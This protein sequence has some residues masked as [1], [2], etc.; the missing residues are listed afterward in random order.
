MNAV[1]EVVEEENMGYILHKLDVDVV[2]MVDVVVN[3]H[4]LRE[5]STITVKILWL[6]PTK[7]LNQR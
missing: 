6:V 5:R 2:D 4:Y 1:A 7:H 3:H